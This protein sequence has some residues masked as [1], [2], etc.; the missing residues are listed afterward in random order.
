MNF[1]LS[2][3]NALRG[4]T[5]V[6]RHRQSQVPS[7]T[8]PQ[9]GEFI[10]VSFLF[11]NGSPD[12]QK[13]LVH[14]LYCN[15]VCSFRGSGQNRNKADGETL[16]R[17]RG[18]HRNVRYC[19]GWRWKCCLLGAIKAACGRFAIEMWG[20]C[21]AGGAS[22]RPTF[23]MQEGTAR[24]KNITHA[25]PAPDTLRTVTEDAEHD[26]SYYCPNPPPGTGQKQLQEGE[27]SPKNNAE[28]GFLP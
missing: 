8:P 10:S 4:V 5:F 20:L 3:G 28:K 6:R 1:A 7:L 15:F 12:A 27:S 2:G 25:K 9:A 21:R 13:R 24:Q 14:R 19:H 23:P 22:R 26:E 11:Q 16:T 17:G 18:V